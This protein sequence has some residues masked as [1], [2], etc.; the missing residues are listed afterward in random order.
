MMKVLDSLKNLGDKVKSSVE[1]AKVAEAVNERLAQAGD[2]LKGVGSK[3]GD[4][5]A[6]I[7]T[8]KLGEAVDERLTQAGDALKTVGE[9]VKQELT[10]GPDRWVKPAGAVKPSL[11]EST[12][13]VSDSIKNGRTLR[14]VFRHGQD[15]M[16]ELDAELVQAQNGLQPGPDGVVGEAIDVI[17]CMLDLI[18][19]ERPDMTEVE[20]AAYAEQ[21][22]AKWQ[23]GEEAKAKA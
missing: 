19:L 21:K 7:D 22:L 3:I 6:Q 9:K 8:K 20:I 1:Q 15:E 17:L 11:I 12:F 14:D 4:G 5:I 10:P 18:H 2:A 13:A 16:D 23:A